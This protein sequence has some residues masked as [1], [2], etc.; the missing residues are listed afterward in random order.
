MLLLSSSSSCLLLLLLLYNLLKLSKS[1]DGKNQANN[2]TN[3][4]EPRLE[5]R[6]PSKFP[7]V[8]I[9]EKISNHTVVA[10]VIVNDEDS[11]PN[12]ETSL[13]IEHGNELAHF[14]LVSTQ[15]S[16]TI[17]VNGA[18]LSR[19][20]VPEYNLTIVAR[21]HGS[22]PKSS[23]VNLVIKLNT[24][25]TTSTSSSNAATPPT[26]GLSPWSEPSSNQPVTDLMYV[27]LM[28]VVIFSAL[29]LIIIIA[30]AIVHKPNNKK[31]APPRTTRM[32]HQP[33]HCFCVSRPT[34][35]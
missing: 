17:Q 18:P 3:L 10:A 5:L 23:A 28:L 13:T 32:H 25:S 15:F 1:C 21:D 2:T 27:G 31:V 30:C 20:R 19:S 11:G 34:N 4:H 6:Y 7:Y 8:S 35:L 24:S 14:K 12:G 22:P 26:G 9:D 16:N 29:I 33:E